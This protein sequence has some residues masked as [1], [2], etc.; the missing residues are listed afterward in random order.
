MIRRITHLTELV[1]D[2]VRRIEIALAHFDPVTDRMTD[3]VRVF[4]C[5]DTTSIVKCRV[6]PVAIHDVVG[7]NQETRNRLDLVIENEHV[8]VIVAN[9]R[10]SPDRIDLHAAGR[11]TLRHVRLSGAEPTKVGVK[12]LGAVI[13]HDTVMGESRIGPIEVAEQRMVSE[14][15]ILTAGLHAQTLHAGKVPDQHVGSTHTHGAMI[16]GRISATSRTRGSIGTP[17]RRVNELHIEVHI[18]RHI[19]ADAQAGHLLREHIVGRPFSSVA[20][21]G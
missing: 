21:S 5:S 20:P 18:R 10:V 19:V 8:C 16:Q 15:D 12:S 2:F 9:A 13:Q 7:L 3:L 1:D 6:H 17:G 11:G 14:D 4:C